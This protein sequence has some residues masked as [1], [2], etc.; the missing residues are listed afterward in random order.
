MNQECTKK[1][2][3]VLARFL[4]PFCI[5]GDYM[6][7]DEIA[8][9]VFDVVNGLLA[10]QT[11]PENEWDKLEKKLPEVAYYNRWDRCKTLRKGFCKK[12]YLFIEKDKKEILPD[13]LL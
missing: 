11:F 10:T 12:G 2:K 7:E 3:E 4:V 6:V 9:F 5:T 8:K 1:E 13:Y